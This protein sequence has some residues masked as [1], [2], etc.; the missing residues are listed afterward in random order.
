MVKSVTI[1]KTLTFEAA[2]FIPG[3]PSGHPCGRVH[4][5]S[6]I[7][8]VGVSGPV[9]TAPEWVRDFADLKHSLGPLLDRLDHRTLN[10]IPG[11]EG[12]TAECLALWIGARLVEP[13][14]SPTPLVGLKFVKVWETKNSCVECEF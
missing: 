3:L 4:G 11:L 7:V 5:H 12:G 14:T 2:H 6:Y 8:E 10:D 1:S 9:G 13:M